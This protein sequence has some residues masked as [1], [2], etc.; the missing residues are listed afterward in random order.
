MMVND[1]LY[2]RTA[3]QP[4]WAPVEADAGYRH[5]DLW[6]ESADLQRQIQAIKVKQADREAFDQYDQLVKESDPETLRVQLTA[7]L[8]ALTKA[9]AAPGAPTLESVVLVVEARLFNAVA[10]PASSSVAALTASLA[11]P[12]PLAATANL[13]DRN[14]RVVNLLYKNLL[15]STLLAEASRNADQ[16]KA[17]LAQTSGLQYYLLNAYD[18]RN[19]PEYPAGEGNY[20]PEGQYFLMGDNRYNS[21]DFRFEAEMRT[22]MRALDPA[23][24]TSTTYLSMLAP[25]LL[26]RV[27][28]IGHLAFRLW[29]LNRI[30][31]E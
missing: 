9:L 1:Q 5:V 11:A 30:M 29:P 31:V 3:S 24:P 25:R 23:D 17:M 27:N 12:A 22:Q 19:F 6:K 8:V 4:E 21:L 7:Q 14:A 20:I 15:V 16:S 18:M 2:A 26:P 10:F 13:Y 28:I